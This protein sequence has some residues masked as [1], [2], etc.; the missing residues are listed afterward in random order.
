MNLQ[1]LRLIVCG[2][3]TD[4]G[5]TVVSSFLVQ[6]LKAMYWKP[7]QSGLEDGGDRGRINQLL[8]MPQERSLP[9][10]YNF[11]AAVSP[12]WAAE[13]ENTE[14]EPRKLKLPLVNQP[15]IIET[16]GGLFVPLNRQLLQIDHLVFWKLPVLLVARST[17]GT[18][19]HTLLSIE[20]LKARGIPITG[21]IP[22]VIEI[23]I[24]K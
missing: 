13:K 7:I 2:T 12:H 18:L 24:E 8:K 3:D 1:S 20:A 21:N 9:E 23:F 19:N 4:V 5:K 16:A 15:L 10:I 6:G 11:K 17:L 22:N 14:I